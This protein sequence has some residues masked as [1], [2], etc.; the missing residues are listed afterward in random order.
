MALIWGIAVWTVFVAQGYCIGQPL[1]KTKY[2][3]A[4]LVENFKTQNKF[5]HIFKSVI[6]FW[7]ISPFLCKIELKAL[8]KSTNLQI[9]GMDFTLM[10]V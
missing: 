5:K 8:N 10:L 7:T 4:K 1:A 9:W 3:L 6:K 2:V